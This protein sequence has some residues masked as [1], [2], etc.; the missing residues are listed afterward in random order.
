MT[1]PPP[2]IDPSEPIEATLLHR[3][4]DRSASREDW[5]ALRALAADDDGVWR[6]LADALE[7]EGRVVRAVAPVADAADRIALPPAGPT[8]DAERAGERPIRLARAGAVGWAAAA[9]LLLAWVNERR[10]DPAPP[11]RPTTFAPS[12]PEAAAEPRGS[13][14]GATE[15]VSELPAR[16]LDSRPAASG[17][18]YD[19]LVLRR[20]VE[21][22]HVETLYRLAEDE[23]GRP[24]PVPEPFSPAGPPER[25]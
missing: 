8:A 16:M 24:V 13:G 17:D 3:A 18:G 7:D 11:D 1:L 5:A 2:A 10:E 23:H 19:V 9:L 25:M 22:R 20:T 21:R 6:R 14:S 4:L 15:I 12:P